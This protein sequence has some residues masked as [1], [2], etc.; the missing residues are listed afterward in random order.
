M[1]GVAVGN[2]F[3]VIGGVGKP[4]AVI[5]MGQ[6]DQRHGKGKAL[7]AAGNEIL[8]IIIGHVR[9]RKR[10][11]V[12]EEC[13]RQ[14]AVRQHDGFQHSQGGTAGV[15]RKAAAIGEFTAEHVDGNDVLVSHD[16]EGIVGAL[17]LAIGIAAAIGIDNAMIGRVIQ[18]VPYQLGLAAGAD[19]GGGDPEAKGGGAV[20]AGRCKRDVLDFLRHAIH[21]GEDHLFLIGRQ[22]AAVLRG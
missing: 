12:A 17:R 8:G 5:V 22:T 1:R 9:L 14:R 15:G 4:A 6:V 18:I 19:G 10:Y 3:E 7:R 20:S 13:Q 16:R 2:K 21:P 11:D